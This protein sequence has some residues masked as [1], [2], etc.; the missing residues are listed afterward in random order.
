MLVLFYLSGLGRL[1]GRAY[2]VI[3]QSAS[4]SQPREIVYILRVGLR[5]ELEPIHYFLARVFIVT[6]NLGRDERLGN[7]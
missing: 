2:P 4:D 3:Q 7:A 6:E 1:A 5:R